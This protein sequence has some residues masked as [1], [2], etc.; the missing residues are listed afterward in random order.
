MPKKM[1]TCTWAP[2][3]F[4]GQQVTGG[5]KPK[6]G[7]PGHAALRE[8]VLP[9]VQK[10][11]ELGLSHLLIAQRWWGSGREMESSSLDCLAMTAFLAGQTNRI[12]LVTAIHPGFFEATAIAKW[13]ATMDW[14][15]AG[16]WAI[17]VTSGW[18]LREFD[19]YGIDALEHD[20]RYQRS[21]EFIDVIRGAWTESPF[22][23]HGE[24]YDCNGLQLEP[25]PS[26]P[27]EIFQGGQSEASIQ[28]AAAKSDWMFLNGGSLERIES[29]IQ[30]ARRATKSTGRTL[31]FALYAA[32]ICRDSDKEA[33]NVIQKRVD[34]I[35]P[36]FAK[37]RRRATSGAQGMWSSA[38]ELSLLDSNEGYASRLIGSPKTIIA[39]IEAYQDLG[40]EML[41]FDTS[42]EQFL[43]DVLPEIQ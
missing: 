1:Y 35:D 26:T 22:N 34:A 42:D 40:I 5:E 12:H 14:L 20:Q 13:G 27:I 36:D 4:A 37:N 3:V 18:N 7:F 8:F 38:E 17:N 2:T 25:P 43:R 41:H 19:M 21:S 16:R 29:V 30:K 28:M 9:R 24:F 15:S 31:H 23:Y 39:R 10:I 32:P 6:S 11:E 33:W